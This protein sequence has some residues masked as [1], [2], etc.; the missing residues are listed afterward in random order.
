MTCKFALKCSIREK[1]LV[2]VNELIKA[3]AKI[4]SIMICFCFL[5]EYLVYIYIHIYVYISKCAVS[6]TSNLRGVATKYHLLN[7]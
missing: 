4:F 3:I 7:I 1:W 6:L 5:L 2:N